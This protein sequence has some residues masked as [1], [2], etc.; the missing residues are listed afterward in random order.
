[1]ED[2]NRVIAGFILTHS[3][4]LLWLLV[5][6]VTIVRHLVGVVGMVTRAGGTS[7]TTGV[8]QHDWMVLH[9]WFLV[10]LKC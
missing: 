8:I 9:D 7:T 1:M 5:Y 2:R 4:M 6:V 10:G 3:R